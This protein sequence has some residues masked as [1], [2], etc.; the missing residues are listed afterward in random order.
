MVAVVYSGSRTAFWKL[1][2]NGEVVAHC[3]TAGINPCF[4][5]EKTRLQILNKKVALINN[6]ENIKKIYFFKNWFLYSKYLN[7][8]YQN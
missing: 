2:Q 6:A 7:L 3:N 5:D 1:T 4:V 8:R